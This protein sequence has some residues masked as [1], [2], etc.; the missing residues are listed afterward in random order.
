VA[1]FSLLH[2]QHLPRALDGAIEPPL[3]M[4][5]Q[6]G[7][8]AGQNASLVRHK[9]AQQRNILVIQR[10]E[11]EIILGLGRGARVSP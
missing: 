6:P 9:L 5:R 8:F 7:I 3:V 2:E 10:I 4:R 1:F 11:R